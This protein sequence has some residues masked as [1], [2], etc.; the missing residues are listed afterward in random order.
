M[1]DVKKIRQDFP[2]LDNKVMQGHPLVYFDSAATSLK[3][4][5]VIEAMNDYYYNFNS[6]VHRGDY[7]IAAK[8]DQIYEK[9]REVV[10]NFIN[11]NTK[12][13]RRIKNR[14]DN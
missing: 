12:D 6:N 10:A 7:D 8:A 4:R 13:D 11:A 5:C 1:L 3:P 9:S 2:M 14:G